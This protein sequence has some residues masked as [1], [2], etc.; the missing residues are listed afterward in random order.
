MNIKF[1]VFVG[2]TLLVLAQGQAR[3][4][5]TTARNRAQLIEQV[6][7]PF[8]VPKVQTFTTTAP[9]PAVVPLPK[10]NTK[11]NVNTY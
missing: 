5:I 11:K 1:V 3:P 8:S 2:M 9:P 10:N 4:G 7:T 6:A